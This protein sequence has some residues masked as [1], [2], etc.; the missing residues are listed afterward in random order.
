MRVLRSASSR[1]DRSPDR[2]RVDIECITRIVRP[3]VLRAANTTLEVP[4]CDS[5]TSALH[6]RRSATS[7]LPLRPSAAE[8]PL[9]DASGPYPTAVSLAASG[10]SPSNVLI[11][12]EQELRLAD[13]IQQLPADYR[14][15]ILL[16]NFERLPFADIA[17]RLGRSRPAVQML[18]LRA[19]VKLQELLG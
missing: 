18:W 17:E 11:A 10:A 15:V 1:V 7:A 19:L 5:A 8:L 14:D 12:R 16:R 3:R 4:R 6:L 9:G 13:A 2:A